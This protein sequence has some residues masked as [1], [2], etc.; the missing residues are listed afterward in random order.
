MTCDVGELRLL[1]LVHHAV[2]MMMFHIV[3]GVN[4]GR[5]CRS[6]PG[7]LILGDTHR[8]LVQPDLNF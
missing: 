7:N 6:H 5:R 1:C 3:F 4:G 2:V 8:L